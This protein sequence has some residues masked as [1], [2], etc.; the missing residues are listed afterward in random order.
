MSQSDPTTRR[1]F[2]AAA[3]RLV[4]LAAVGSAAGVLTACGG[5]GGPSSPSSA[6]S[7]PL[8][9]GSTANGKVTVAVGSGSPLASVGGA[10]L[11]QTGGS[12]LLVAQ[13][14]QDSFTALTAICTHQTCII[15]GH[16]G[17]T[18]ICPCHGSE[19][20]EQGNVLSGPAPRP[21]QSLP[22]QFSNGVL[23]IG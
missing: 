5:G 12:P 6:S 14:A 19:Y 2:C 16:S 1:G 18:Y 20:D 3:C 7:L 23:T 10:A 17:S 9:Q 21:L 22:T 4:S 8:I 11:V 13:T 15:T